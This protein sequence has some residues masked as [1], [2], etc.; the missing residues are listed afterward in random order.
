MYVIFISNS[1]ININVIYEYSFGEDVEYINN[2]YDKFI[3]NP[4]NYFDFEYLCLLIL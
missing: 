4:L 2:N 1:K 3:N